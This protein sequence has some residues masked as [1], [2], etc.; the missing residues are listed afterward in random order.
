MLSVS[1]NDS[2][3]RDND[4]LQEKIIKKLSSNCKYH[5]GNKELLICGNLW[6]MWK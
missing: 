1:L 2:S 3:I 4:K 5:S 6:P